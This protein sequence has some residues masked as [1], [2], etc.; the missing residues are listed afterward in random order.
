MRRMCRIWF[1]S[2]QEWQSANLATYSWPRANLVESS[3][4][5]VPFF[6]AVER[7]FSGEIEHE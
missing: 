7:G 4:L 2:G 1:Q 6:D 5:P 3:S